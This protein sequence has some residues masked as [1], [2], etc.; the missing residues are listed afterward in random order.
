MPTFQMLGSLDDLDQGDDRPAIRLSFK[1][2]EL[3]FFRRALVEFECDEIAGYYDRA[4][5]PFA[6]RLDA[7]TRG[8][9]IYKSAVGFDRVRHAEDIAG[10][11]IISGAVIEIGQHQTMAKAPTS[12]KS[13]HRDRVF[14]A[15]RLRKIR[16]H[17]EKSVDE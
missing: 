1:R 16:L 9:F 12:R 3:I 11:R 14:R 5:S 7:I 15:R 6:N 10:M 8:E 4:V 13:R 2:D 17:Q